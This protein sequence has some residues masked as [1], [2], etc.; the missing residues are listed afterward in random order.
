M[1]T[2]E[3]DQRVRSGEADRDPV[4]A[5]DGAH[6]SG[7]LDELQRRGRYVLLGRLG[8]GGMGVVHAAYDPSLDR[9]VALKLLRP[10]EGGNVDAVAR[11]RLLR[12]AR[13]LARLSHPNVVHVYEVGTI[14]DQ[15]VYI[16]MEHVEGQTLLAWQ[17]AA[18]RPFRDVLARYRAAGRGLQ[19]AHE[20]GLVH[21]DFKPENVV[22]GKDGRVVVLDFGLAVAPEAGASGAETAAAS[23]ASLTSTTT[24]AP[25]ERLLPGGKDRAA[26]PAAPVAAGALDP[27]DAPASGAGH[28]R[29]SPDVPFGAR[30]L[31]RYTVDILGTQPYMAPEQH[32]GHPIDART[33]QYSF[34]VA[35]YEGLYGER[36]F[37]EGEPPAD[38]VGATMAAGEAPGETGRARPSWLVMQKFL[39]RVQPPPPHSDVPGWLRQV[40]LRGLS[41]EPGERW[42]SMADLLIELSRDPAARRRRWMAAAGVAA[43][44]GALGVSYSRVQHERSRLCQGAAQKLRG[45]WDAERRGQVRGAFE[46]TSAPEADAAFARAAHALDG[47]AGRWIAMHTSACESTRLHGEQSEDLLDLRMQCLGE[48]LDALR[49]TVD[50]LAAADSTVVA[51]ASAAMTALPPLD[52]CANPALLRASVRP[53]ADPAAR[54]RLVGLRRRLAEARTRANVGKVAEALA[55]ATAIAG[56]ARALGYRPFEAAALIS[57]STIRERA[58]DWQ[59]ALDAARDAMRAADAGH[60]GAQAAEAQSYITFLLGTRLGRPAEAEA[61][62]R[63][64]EARLEGLSEIDPR[65]RVNILKFCATGFMSA[66][67]PEEARARYVAA[68]ALLDQRRPP[69]GA[70]AA[71]EASPGREP[72]RGREA[73][74][75]DEVASS[76]GGLL[77]HLA[78]IDAQVGRFSSAFVLFQQAAAAYTQAFGERNPDVALFTL[79]VGVMHYLLG[80]EREAE[81]ALERARSLIDRFSPDSPIKVTALDYLGFVTLRRGELDRARQ[82]FQ[83]ALE[84]IERSKLADHPAL[85]ITLLGLARHQLQAATTTTTTDARAIV[86]MLERAAAV[87]ERTHADPWE[88][89]WVRFELVRALAG[90]PHDPGRIH[91]L[92]EQVRETYAQLPELAGPERADFESWLARHP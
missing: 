29:S 58:G 36:P 15:Q 64:A 85:P 9:K 12:E 76:R 74:G 4:A 66:G 80:E 8:S 51:R 88:L 41:P 31:D 18:R 10:G 92:V 3:N 78:W 84:I 21:R 79:D 70:P 1:S 83:Q 71:G 73:N 55:G 91:H 14:E 17:K 7:P 47:Y 32:V 22:L 19:A 42:P 25:T 50:V 39:R 52:D 44:A 89:A 90:Q 24:E 59:G 6:A 62:A 16:A 23:P 86:A 49:A 5:P 33:D 27:A 13:A 46:A 68:L 82:L 11:G 48:R 38:E 45:V 57:L 26:H 69:A 34:C 81:A 35:L 67:K 53:P 60:D 77:S 40:V 63:D 20:A 56:E 2:A 37:L 75:D 28:D 87:G 72:P 61:A 30:P 65:R 54:D 43:I